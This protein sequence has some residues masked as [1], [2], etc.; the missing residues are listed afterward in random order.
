MS[1]T[2]LR[3]PSDEPAPAVTQTTDDETWSAEEPWRGG[4]HTALVIA[5]VFLGLLLVILAAMLFTGIRENG[6]LSDLTAALRESV[7]SLTAEN[8]ALQSEL[9]VLRAEFGYFDLSTDDAEPLGVGT[10]VEVPLSETDPLPAFQFSAEPGG[11]GVIT[12]EILSGRAYPYLELTDE[13]GMFVADS[14]AYDAGSDLTLWH[15]FPDEGP[16]FAHLFGEGRAEARLTLDLY[17]VAGSDTVLEVDDVL[18]VDGTPLL[19]TFD[20]EAGQLATVS[21]NAARRHAL[22]PYLLLYGPDGALVTEDDDGGGEGDARM[23]VVLPDDGIYEVEA[24]SYDEYHNEN[25]AEQH[26]F[27]LIVELADLRPAG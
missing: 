25:R 20:G 12:V 10:P 8:V 3:T 6:R 13:N 24:S 4:R 18:P 7:A 26:G 17:E 21:M 11:L 27:T 2:K 9:E 23:M 19:Y 1:D 22:D 15:E 5:V 14:Y 16:Y